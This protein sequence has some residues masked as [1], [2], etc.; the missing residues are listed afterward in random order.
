M[1][2]CRNLDKLF[3]AALIPEAF[4]GFQIIPDL[5]QC[6]DLSRLISAPRKCK[7]TGED[8][9]RGEHHERDRE[10]VR[11][12]QKRHVCAKTSNHR[13]NKLTQGQWADKLVLGFNIL[14]NFIAGH[15]ISI[16]DCASSYQKLRTD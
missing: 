13:I 1:F 16:A 12:R 11:Q 15:T 6:P 8:H 4:A 9:R 10:V 7:K 2:R 5:G 14:D 3:D